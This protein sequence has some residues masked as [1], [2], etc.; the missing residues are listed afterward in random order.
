MKRLI[1]TLFAVILLTSVT[2]SANRDCIFEVINVHDG[3]VLKKGDLGTEGNEYGFEGGRAFRFK[4]EYHMFTSETFGDPKWVKMRLAHWKSKD[5]I[6]WERVS[7]LYESSGDFTGKDPRAAFWSP[8]PYYNE[9]EGRWNLTYVAYKCKPSTDHSWYINHE[10]RIWRAVSSVLG[11]D[12]LDGPYVDLRIILEPG[13][14]SNPW[15]GLQGTDSFFM[16]PVGDKWYAFYGSANTEHWPCSFWGVG[17]A[18][19]D[20]MAGPWKR[21]NELNPVDLKSKFAENPVVTQFP[22]GTYIAMVDGGGINR[23]FGYTLSKDGIHWTKATFINLEPEVKKWWTLMRTPL[24][25]IPEGDNI[26]TVFF[27]ALMEMQDVEDKHDESI[28]SKRTYGVLGVVRLKLK[29][30]DVITKALTAEGISCEKKTTS[31]NK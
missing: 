5:G 21:C 13:P 1:S 15:E 4:G 22:D 3:P 23:T 26:Y 27:T 18:K 31:K 14:D 8:M 20:D 6:K 17:L 9:K 30:D 25:L 10:G 28:T 24:G 16:Y 19:A 2:A 11:K 29:S 7:T 12:G